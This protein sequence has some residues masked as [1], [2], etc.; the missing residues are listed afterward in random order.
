MTSFPYGKSI[1]PA[2]VGFDRLISTL[3]ETIDYFGDRKT[4]PPY[5][6]I[7]V[8]PT[9]YKIVVAIA[10]FDAEELDI[11]IQKDSLVITGAKKL[12]ISTDPVDYIYQGLALR[13]FSHRFKLADNVTVGAAKVRDGLLTIQLN[14]IVPE[15]KPARKVTIQT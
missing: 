10:G 13:N 8:D 11:E 2:S 12:D 3:E 5:N 14:S 9:T 1:L 15:V 7:R 4:Y 6:I